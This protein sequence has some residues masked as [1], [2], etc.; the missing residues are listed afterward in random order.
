[1]DN[2]NTNT[3]EGRTQQFLNFDLDSEVFAV[4]IDK[5]REVL[6]YETVTRIPQ[7]PDFMTGVINLR[8]SV[9]P[10]IDMRKKFRLSEKEI[11][12]DTCIIIVEV[13]VDGSSVVIGA[14][15]DAVREVF[16]LSLEEIEPVPQIG[17]QLSP[18]FLRGMAQKNNEFVLIMDI[19]KVFSVGEIELI[20]EAELSAQT[21]EVK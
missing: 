18:E 14:L 10:V 1:M 19:D 21:A 11:T 13:S 16:D 17:T 20:G 7:T 15:A 4:E 6:D 8:G 2:I 12:E 3:T 5:V 9:V